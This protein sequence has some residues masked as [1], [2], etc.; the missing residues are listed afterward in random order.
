MKR[1]DFLESGATLALGAVA[2]GITGVMQA[3]PTQSL[4]RSINGMTAANPLVESYAKAVGLMKNLPS[5]DPR[6]WTQ[7]A[8]IHN[9]FCP[10]NNWWFLPWHRAYLFYFESICRD[11]LQD[12]A[13]ALPYWDWTAYPR[14]PSPFLD[15]ASPLWDARRDA[16]GNI[17]LG[18]EI[19]GP[20]VISGIVGSGS[21][22]DL[23]SS[24]TTSDD[25]RQRA[26]AGALEETPHNGVH[27]TILG[28]MGTY[29]SPLDPIFWLHHCNV[30]R[31]WA[32]W[33]RLNGNLAPTAR[34]WT[35]H[36]LTRFYD[37]T[38][39]NAMSP[40]TGDTL[41]AEKY[42]A[43]YDRYET[44]VRASLRPSASSLRTA[45][46][47]TGAVT[48]AAGVRQVEGGRL[49]GREVTLGTAQ[50]FQLAVSPDFVPLIQKGVSSSAVE[51]VQT[52]ATYLVIENV[53][54]P[55][56]E[57]TALRVFLNCKNPS[58]ETSLDDPTYVGT[59]AFFGG[60]HEL[61]LHPDTTFTIDV[62][63]ALTKVVRAGIYSVG[64]PID[65]AVLPLDL[66]NPNRIAQDEVLK[67]GGIRLVGL[68]AMSNT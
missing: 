56:A 58:L 54:R 66:A 35:N 34:L 42:R 25:Q 43:I 1:R 63:T 52:T 44:P 22:V 9:N 32:S 36:R 5:G 41:D 30:D 53:P 64:A 7:Q 15:Q 38:N 11:V 51:T 37:P 2:L 21:L 13:F 67:P 14:I 29:L 61:G 31:I 28:D 26:S 17:Q 23:F 10:H 6:N 16:N 24:P 47:G 12:S 50:Q 33:S 18:I 59:V 62:T 46:L 39:K 27:G 68:E 65:V 48:S 8:N 20:K 19:V 4:R 49:A 60:A 3:Q 55:S 57:G 40:S 45:M